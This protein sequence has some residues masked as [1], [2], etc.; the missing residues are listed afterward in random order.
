MPSPP[1]AGRRLLRAYIDETGD[2][3]TS[4]KSSNFFAFAAVV[5]ADEEDPLLRAAVTRLRSDF[6]VPMGAPL[7]WKDHVKVFARRQHTARVLGAV[8]NLSVNYVA[9]EKAAIPPTAA[10]RTDHEK[11]Y[12]FAAGLILERILLCARHWPGGARDVKVRFGHVRG[13]DHSATTRYF[14]IKR[15]Q[16]DR[17][18][19]AL[20]RGAVEWDGMGNWDGLQA[21]DQFAGMLNAAISEDTFGGFEPAHLLQVR[22]LIRRSPTGNSW[23][24]GF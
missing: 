7:H 2:R 13:F 9:V 14:A 5:V 20:Q 22:H 19:W 15:S 23:G 10:L 24:Y 8:G 18:P 4:G 17:I 11:F 3:G 16:D 21:A 1:E 6:G 12:N